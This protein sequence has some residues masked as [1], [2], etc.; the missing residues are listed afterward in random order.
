MAHFTVDARLTKLQVVG[1]ESPTP[2]VPQLDGMTNGAVGLITRLC[3]EPF[4][5]RLARILPH[6]L[7]SRSSA[8]ADELRCIESETHESVHSAIASEAKP[9]APDT[10]RKV[11]HQR[12][13]RGFSSVPESSALGLPPKW[14]DSPVEV[15]ATSLSR[16]E[17]GPHYPVESKPATA[18]DAV[19]GGL[20][21]I[22][23]P[24]PAL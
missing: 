11:K 19:V 17:H 9:F 23:W 8:S 12:G 1:F 7:L 10:F 21:P 15:S 6:Q 18:K 16:F 20:H 2:T 3:A 4:E 5:R 24:R 14:L 22:E 13:G